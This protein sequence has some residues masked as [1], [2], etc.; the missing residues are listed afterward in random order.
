MQALNP[1]V[2]DQSTLSYLE[3]GEGLEL[4]EVD[5]TSDDGEEDKVD[6]VV[7][8]GRMLWRELRQHKRGERGD[9]ASVRG[10]YVC[11]SRGYAAGECVR[12]FVCGRGEDGRT[13][14][15]LTCN[16]GIII[17]GSY[18]PIASFIRYS[19]TFVSANHVP[20]VA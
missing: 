14:L 11:V 18:F 20:K 19:H 7:R 12:V 9:A 13:T 8:T 2:P 3:I 1:P 16:S 15:P 10:R 17:M 4:L 6:L 5:A